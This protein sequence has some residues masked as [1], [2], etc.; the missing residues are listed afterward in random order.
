M[1]MLKRD[2]IRSRKAW[3]VDVG[4]KCLSR[5]T[6]ILMGHT[7]A[8]KRQNTHSSLL[9]Y[10]AEQEPGHSVWGL[11]IRVFLSKLAKN[12][13]SFYFMEIIFGLFVLLLGFCDFYYCYNLQSG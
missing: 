6:F 4:P 2:G 5:H 10:I 13:P 3:Q 9:Q 1:A 12:N 8:P 11:F 7:A